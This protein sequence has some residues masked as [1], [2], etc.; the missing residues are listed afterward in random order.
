MTQANKKMSVEELIIYLKEI[1]LNADITAC[2]EEEGVLNWGYIDDRH[3]LI[4][5]AVYVANQVLILPEGKRDFENE[6]KVRL[7]GFYISCRESDS[8]G[9]LEGG[10]HTT[11]GV[12]AYG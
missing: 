2:T 1:E 11:K 5:N 7:E 6:S 9:W 10:I 12:I 4:R 3:L 8:F